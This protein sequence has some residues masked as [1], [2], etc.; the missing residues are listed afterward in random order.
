MHRFQ[1]GV[2]K[3][4]FL[5]TFSEI[6]KNRKKILFLKTLEKWGKEEKT[7]LMVLSAQNKYNN[8]I[9]LKFSKIFFFSIFFNFWK[10][11]NFK[12]ALSEEKIKLANF[13]FYHI[14]LKLYCN[15]YEPAACRLPKKGKFGPPYI[16]YKTQSPKLIKKRAIRVFTF[17]DREN[18]LFSVLPISML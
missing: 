5:P 11:M 15:Y 14:F 13:N 12:W 1:G 4:N 18:R 16:V 8:Y 9:F 17:F 3:K 7:P 2:S 10:F 6:T